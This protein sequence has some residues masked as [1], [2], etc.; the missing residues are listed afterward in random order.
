MKCSDCGAEN[1][2]WA[3]N[4]GKCGKALAQ[5][6][7]GSA[8]SAAGMRPNEAAVEHRYIPGKMKLDYMHGI[9]DVTQKRLDALQGLL[10][11]FRTPQL[12]ID[13][14][15]QDAA[16][17]ISKQM[18]IDNVSIGLRDPKDGLYRYRAMVGFR[19]EAAEALKRIAY[20]KEQFYDDANY[21][22]SDISKQTRLYLAENNA[23]VEGEQDTFNRPVLL[24]MKRRTA[25]DSLEG[26]YIDV[27]IWGLYDDLLGWIELSGTRTMQF[28][29][30]NSI[31]WI[32]T[33]A[34]II[35]IAVL[36]KPARG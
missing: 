17:L 19:D 35:G 11:H 27:K 23:P 31:R 6:G 2:E 33:V 3:R 22:G 15:L 32:E 5:Q 21:V 25:L 4:C 9:R 29:D 36:F 10:A 7:D 34:S 18:S 12:N 16:T 20:R 1:S 24:A 28:P 30:T 14:F 13:A 8:R 26:D